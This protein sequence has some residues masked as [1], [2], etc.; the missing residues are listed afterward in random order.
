MNCLDRPMTMSLFVKVCFQ[1]SAYRFR[2]LF[3]L[4]R[5]ESIDRRRID[6]ALLIDC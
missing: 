6:M 1:S 5:Y 2:Q 4:Q 3:I